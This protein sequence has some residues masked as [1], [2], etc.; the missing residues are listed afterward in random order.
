MIV[1]WFL[2]TRAFL[3]KVPWQAYAIAGALLLAFLWG[4][5]RYSQGYAAS[6]AKHAAIAAQAVTDARKADAAGMETAQAGKALSGAEI[7]RGRD[8]AA[9]ATDDPWKSATEAMR[10]R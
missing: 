1:S 6:E 3:A 4:N 8:A 2:T 10:P 7:E 5:H 9:K